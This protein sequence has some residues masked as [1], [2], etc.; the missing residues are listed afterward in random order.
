MKERPI[1]FKG[2][3]VRAVLEGRKTQTRRV[4]KPCFGEPDKWGV[5]GSESEPTHGEFAMCHEDGGESPTPEEIAF[6]MSECTCG[7]AGVEHC[8][9]LPDDFEICESCKTPLKNPNLFPERL[10]HCPYGAVGDRLW[11]RESGKITGK[12]YTGENGE[13]WSYG[14]GCW[15]YKE[16]GVLRNTNQIAFGPNWKSTPSIHMPR[17]ASRITL[18]VV[19]VRVERVESV[20]ADDGQAEGFHGPNSFL[21]LFYEINV[22]RG[23]GEGTNPWVWVVE[24]KQ[25]GGE[26]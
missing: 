23:F 21:D 12:G 22:A 26:S 25:I 24:F 8:S 20:T 10:I 1:L 9:E 19:S 13:R 14:D 4:V 11:V 7:L 3:M 18:E 17:W 6:S 16:D 2:E 5:W 15:K